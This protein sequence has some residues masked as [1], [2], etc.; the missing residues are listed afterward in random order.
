MQKKQQQ[1]KQKKK[2]FVGVAIRRTDTHKKSQECK[3]MNHYR[4]L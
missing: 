3:T 4:Q 2:R 1:K